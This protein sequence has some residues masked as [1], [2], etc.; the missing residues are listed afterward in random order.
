MNEKE[1]IERLIAGEERAFRY[2]IKIHKGKILN[3]CFK[4][5]NNYEDAEDA[6]QETLIEIFK[7]ISKFNQNSNLS[8]WTYRI[9]VNKSIDMIRTKK[10]R[11]K[12]AG[13]ISIFSLEFKNHKQ[14]LHSPDNPQKQIEKNENQELLNQA[15]AKLPEN[16]RIAITLIKL[17]DMTY[18][19]ASEV[20]DVTVQ[21][22]ESLMIRAK[23]NLKKIIDKRMFLNN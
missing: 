2:F 19:E 4:F 13:F 22:V 23:N 1:L 12:I 15:L 10:R 8:T 6:A 21:A 18:K 5:L 16:Q 20:M 3:T 14:K 11:D 7:S 17:Q 9:A